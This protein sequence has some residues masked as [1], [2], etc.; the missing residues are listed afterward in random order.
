MKTLHKRLAA[1]L[2]ALAMTLG[3]LGA[4]AGAT[5]VQQTPEDV[6]AR[7]N[8]VRT[9]LRVR[10][11]MQAISGLLGM[12][13]VGVG[14]EQGAAMAAVTQAL[15]AM[16]K[17]KTTV[18]F[19]RDAISLTLGSELANLMD[20]QFTPRDSDGA[21]AITTSLLP[22]LKLTVPPIPELLQYQALIE[23]HQKAFR[24]T[25]FD[26]LLA[27]YAEALNTYFTQTLPAGA[28]QVSGAF[29]I[30]D[31]G[32]FDTLST[33]DVTG[34][35]L[36]GVLSAMVE[37]LKQDTALRQ[38]LDTHLKVFASGEGLPQGFVAEADVGADAPKDS[39]ELIAKLEEGIAEIRKDAGT[40]LGRQSLYTNS[41]STALCLVTEDKDAR[42]LITIAML[43]VENGHDLRVSILMRAEAPVWPTP[44]PSA[45]QAP[46]TPVDWA[47][48]KAGVLAGTDFST[49]FTLDLKSGPDP[50]R[51]RLDTSLGMKMS[52]QGIRFGLQAT[53]ASALIAPYAK[54][55]EVSLS[56][57]GPEPQLTIYYEDTEVSEAPALPDPDTVKAVEFNEQAMEEG[58]EL[59]QAFLQ[60]GLPAL[61]ENLK[62]AL[63]EEAPAILAFIQ[64]LNSQSTPA[65]I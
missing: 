17:L 41:Q 28:A 58:S 27:P 4:M 55:G 65:P 33:Y 9:D 1:L 48:V 13:S 26:K 25:P 5:P 47:A 57:M 2:L 22:G 29:E 37:V 39:A 24:E 59:A 10:L 14:P 3:G 7:G 16:N 6:F 53:D 45:T 64:Q 49:L 8:Y 11:D 56:V 18:V 50:E 32:S 42:S 38:L 36:A 62:L 60:K 30:A 52:L 35:T 40:L 54:K 51:K 20:M 61:L 63:P 19:G 43:P 31:V 34:E 15:S 23:R 12:I 46:K 21:A 44:D